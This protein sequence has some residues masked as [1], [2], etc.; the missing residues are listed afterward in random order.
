MGYYTNYKLTVRDV[1]TSRS[2]LGDFLQ[3]RDDAKEFDGI[4][5]TSKFKDEYIAKLMLASNAAGKINPDIFDVA[6]E[7][8]DSIKWYEHE[9]D[10]LFASTVFPDWIFEL[11]GEGEESGDIW[12]KWFWNGKMQGGKAEVVLPQF[13]PDGWEKKK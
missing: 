4:G 8:C 9:K 3:V 13:K 5:D 7:G 10:M 11:S 6:S 2:V 1:K 12:V